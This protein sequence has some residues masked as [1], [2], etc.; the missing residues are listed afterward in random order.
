MDNTTYEFFITRCWDCDRLKHGASADTWEDLLGKHYNF[1][2]ANVGNFKTTEKEFTKKL[3]QVKGYLDKAYNKL[4]AKATKKKVNPDVIAQLL[5]SRA[6]VAASSEP[7]DIFDVL[8]KAFPLMNE[9][10]L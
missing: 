6:A 3:E 7:K 8:K 1:R 2:N 4:I 9:N 10:N 5:E